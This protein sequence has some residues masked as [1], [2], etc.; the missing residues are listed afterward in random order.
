[1]RGLPLA[2][3]WRLQ[4]PAPAAP[5]PGSTSHSKHQASA[6]GSHLNSTSYVDAPLSWLVDHSRWE[7]YRC[8]FDPDRSSRLLL[9]ALTRVQ[10]LHITGDS[11]PV[12]M[13]VHLCTA[14][15]GTV[16][17]PWSKR[18]F[19]RCIHRSCV[20]AR[21]ARR[22][23]PIM[24]RS[25]PSHRHRDGSSHSSTGFGTSLTRCSSPSTPLRLR[26]ATRNCPSP[27][28]VRAT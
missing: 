1:M 6:P 19:W 3:R 28:S 10:W 16:H 15:N 25:S 2:G 11:N 18:V 20:W 26:R 12:R 21:P 22:M 14:A 17:V 5:V 8:R 24:S 9:R 4:I 27:T 7:P 23:C 13:F